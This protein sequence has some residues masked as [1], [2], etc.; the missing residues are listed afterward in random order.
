M[1]DL[2]AAPA[3]AQQRS[4]LFSL[5]ESSSQRSFYTHTN[6]TFSRV[7]DMPVVHFGGEENANSFR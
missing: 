2:E 3:A 5:P 6:K 1:G 4:E 7:P